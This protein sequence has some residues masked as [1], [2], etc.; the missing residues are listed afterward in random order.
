MRVLEKCVNAD[1]RVDDDVGE[2]IPDQHMPEPVRP[3]PGD[4]HETDESQNKRHFQMHADAQMHRHYTRRYCSDTVLADNA[5]LCFT[6]LDLIF[7]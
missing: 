1:P 4:K 5:P 7:I 3:H 6:V 2:E